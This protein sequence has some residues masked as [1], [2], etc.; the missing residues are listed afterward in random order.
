MMK[1]NILSRFLPPTGSPSVYE[2][3]RQHDADSDTSDLEERAGMDLEGH[4]SKDFS[5]RELEGAMADGK[6]SGSTSP[7]PEFLEPEYSTRASGD[8][9]DKTHVHR[10]SSRRPRW[11]RASSPVHETDEA[12]DDVP[13]S[14]LVEGHRDDDDQTARLPPPPPRDRFDTEAPVPGPSSDGSRVYWESAQTQ[15]SLHSSTQKPTPAKGWSH[16]QHPNLA[17]VDPK[18]KAMWR[19]AN[20]ENLDN[21]IRDVYTYFLGNGIWSILLT[22]ALNLLYVCKTSVLFLLQSLTML[23]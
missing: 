5:D 3:I 20:V 15:Q 13:L 14:L 18:E 9:H 22:R 6:T 10:H 1:S 23:S 17:T 4:Q 8:R 11:M 7:D 12:D 21:F 16:R 2:T 19:W